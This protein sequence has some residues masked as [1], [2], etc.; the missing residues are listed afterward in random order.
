LQSIMG[1]SQDGTGHD[2]LAALRATLEAALVLVGKLN[3]DDLLRR[4]MTTFRAMPSEDR[5]VIIDILE[6]EVLGRLVSRGT[7]RPIG[8]STHVNPNARLYVRSLESDFDRRSFDRDGMVVADIRALRIARLIRDLPDVRTM[9][10]EAMREALDHVDPETWTVAEDL[11]QDVLGCIA[12]A[13]ASARDA[14]PPPS[15]GGDPEPDQSE[16]NQSS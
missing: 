4:M 7:E 14:P 10:K 8:Q 15:A 13:R 3:D 9:F 12:D 6:R 2:A 11:L 16:R 5:P 1:D